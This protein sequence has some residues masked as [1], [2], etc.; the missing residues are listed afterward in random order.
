MPS[1]TISVIGGSD[2]NQSNLELAERVG[3]EIAKRGAILVCG[4]LGGIMEAACK[5]AKLE[6]GQTLGIIPSDAKEHANEFVDIVIPTGIGYLRNFLV[7]RAGDAVIALDGSAG[8]LSEIAIAWF[9]DKPII[10]L[11]PTGG[12]AARLAGEKLDERRTDVIYAASSPE[13]AVEIVFQVM[14]WK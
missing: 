3:A 10:S 13:E 1:R 2:S 14:N 4:G 8:T 7:A 9:S 5:G 12:W 6:G 11:V